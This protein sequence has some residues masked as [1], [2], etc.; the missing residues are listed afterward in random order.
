MLYQEPSDTTAN[1]EHECLA[2]DKILLEQALRN[3]TQFITADAEFAISAFEHITSNQD[4]YS[5][6]KEELELGK[7]PRF[8][9]NYYYYV[10]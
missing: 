6:I 7:S 10:L 2:A 4:M 3:I 9:L 1:D 8:I 5:E